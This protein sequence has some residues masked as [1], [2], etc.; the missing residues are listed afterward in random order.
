LD[1]AEFV[2]QALQAESASAS[3]R[4]AVT[5]R[6]F[7]EADA[8]EARWLQTLSES[9]RR[10]TLRPLYALAWRGRNRQAGMATL[11]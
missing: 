4:R 9:S 5:A 1:E 7:A 11:P 3:E 2:A 8:A 10:S 6:H